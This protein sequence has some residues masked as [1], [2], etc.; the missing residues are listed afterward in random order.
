[1]SVN[2]EGKVLVRIVLLT[3]SAIP[4]MKR[5]P[6]DAKI[7]LFSPNTYKIPSYTGISIKM[8]LS[9]EL[10]PGIHADIVPDVE[11]PSRFKVRVENLV[12]LPCSRKNLE[13]FVYNF[14]AN[15]C[16]IHKGELL[17]AMLV[18]QNFVPDL[19]VYYRNGQRYFDM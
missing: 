7:L 1:M 9:I 10:P 4:P 17:A 11:A 8:D 12:L 18:L 14:S 16:I 2:F 5:N 19:G 6:S 15:L 3:G 13:I